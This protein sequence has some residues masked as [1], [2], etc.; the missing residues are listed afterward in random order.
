VVSSTARAS[1]LIFYKL[2]ELHEDYAL[3]TLISEPIT[4]F[5]ADGGRPR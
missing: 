4:Q 1:V 5:V 2:G 3:P